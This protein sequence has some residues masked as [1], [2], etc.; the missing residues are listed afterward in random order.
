V[1]R[2]AARIGGEIRQVEV[3]A[4]EPRGADTRPGFVLV[5]D[6]P[7]GAVASVDYREGE[8]TLCADGSGRITGIPRAVWDF[9][10]SAYRVVPRWL[11]GRKGLPA[12]LNLVR[13]LRDVCARAAELIDLFAEADIVLEGALRETLSR[14]ALGVGGQSEIAESA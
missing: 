6:Q 1:F 3:F 11:E 4:R 9:A 8:I 12:D 5:P 14:D 7:R 2:D 10:V 13:E